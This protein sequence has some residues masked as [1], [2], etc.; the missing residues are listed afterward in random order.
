M[1]VNFSKLYVVYKEGGVYNLQ[2]ASVE[3]TV[4]YFDKTNNK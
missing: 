4:E 3:F 1:K 2:N